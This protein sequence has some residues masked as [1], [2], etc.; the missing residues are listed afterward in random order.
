M[1]FFA[2]DLYQ[3]TKEDGDPQSVHLCSWPEA[4]EIDAQLIKDMQQTRK[5]ASVGLQLREKAG[6]KLRQ[7]LALLKA[8]VIPSND[9]LIEV[10]KDELNIKSIVGD[11]SL[12]TDAWI[13]TALTDELKEEGSV[14]DMVRLVQGMRKDKGLQMQDRPMLVVTA[15]AVDAK[16]LEKYKDQLVSQTGLGGMCITREDAAELAM[17]FE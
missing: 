5:I 9:D 2:E 16:L 3:K 1:P 6:M 17:Q 7:P 15:N 8:K 10:L 4:G 11:E 13:D 12:E 14:R